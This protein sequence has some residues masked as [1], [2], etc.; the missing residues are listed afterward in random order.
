[1]TVLPT[2]DLRIVETK[3][4][5]SPAALV[6]DVPLSERAARTVF[7]ARQAIQKVLRGEDDRLIVVAGPC[8]IHDVELARDFA[9]RLKE[10]M[11]EVADSLL[12]IMRVYFEKPR[13]TV[14]WKG[15]IN[16]PGLDGSFRINDGLHI[17]RRLLVDL[18]EMGVACAH[19]FLDPISPQ[20]IADLVAWGAI[21]ARTTESQ[22][23]RELASGLSCPIGFK[24]ATDG[25]VQI[26]VDAINAA[27]HPHHFLGVTKSGRTAILATAGNPDCHLILRGGD[28]GPNFDAAS[29]EEASRRMLK[30]ALEPRI[31]I[32]C[33]HANSGKNHER[34]PGVA[35]DVAARIGAGDRRIH[36]V[37][38]EAN[39]LPG[40]QDL[41]PGVPIDYGI[42]IT[43]ACM[44]WDTS[45]QIIGELARAAAARRQR[46]PAA[47]HSLA[48]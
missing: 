48:G 23:H 30:A 27:S 34:Q 18:N 4:L 39:I 13:T 3:E 9:A 32:D 28:R 38:L 44:G 21:G 40:R 24:N 5:I 37:M 12:V 16:D 14:G 26:A 47:A 42:S 2:D 19:E 15:L 8:S 41:K 22:V 43:D 25:G 7:Y 45:A 29:V 33:S 46:N 36:G 11:L 10:L 20:Y 6:R 35:R 31:I 1:M 17:A